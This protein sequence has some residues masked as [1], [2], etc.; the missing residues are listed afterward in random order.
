MRAVRQ[1]RRR[2]IAWAPQVMARLFRVS[3][4]GIFQF[5]VSTASWVGLVRIISSFGDSALAGYTLAIRIL[6]FFFLPAWGMS[7]AAATLVGQNLGAKKPERAEKAVWMTAGFNMA[8]L[9]TVGLLFIAFAESLIGLFTSDPAVTATGVDC[10]RIVSYGYILYALGMVM[11]QA[12][13]GAGDT[14]TPTFINIF[15]FWMFQIPLAYTLAHPL[16]LGPNGVF[17]AIAVAESVMAIV[18]TAVFR[19]GS[20]KQ[21]EI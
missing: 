13:N 15:C 11:V 18:A 21:R 6:V 9:G 16:D 2:D 17:I 20:W 19:R 7:N 3:A 12:F 1:I 10:L 5:L 8:F 4:F 14:M